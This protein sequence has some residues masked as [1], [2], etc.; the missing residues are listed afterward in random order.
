MNLQY[1]ETRVCFY[2]YLYL[3]LFIVFY[4]NNFFF[5]Y[6]YQT[7]VDQLKLN[8]QLSHTI[9]LLFFLHFLTYHNWT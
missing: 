8:I 5:F 4:K 2:L 1:I 9:I 7:R 3:K 6:L